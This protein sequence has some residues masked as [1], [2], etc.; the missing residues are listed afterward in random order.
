ML[1]TLLVVRGETART[2]SMAIALDATNPAA[3]SAEQ[4]SPAMMAPIAGRPVTPTGWLLHVDAKN[5]L[6]THLSPVLDPSGA[7][8]GFQVRLLETMGKAGRV[9]LT[10]ARPLAS[11][12][13]LDLLGNRL[14]PLNVEADKIVM[15]V[16]AQEWVAIEARFA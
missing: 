5:V 9:R 7:C 4:M 14:L 11:A 2:F 6:A 8:V 16:A 13:Q 12:V 3:V 10:S 15:D 1:D